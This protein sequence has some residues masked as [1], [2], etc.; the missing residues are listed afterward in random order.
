MIWRLAWM[1]VLFCCTAVAGW[2]ETRHA[3]LIAVSDYHA[4][5][6]ALAPPLEGPPNDIALMW[7]VLSEEG[8][9]PN[10]ITVLA[11]T[12]LPATAE[13]LADARAPTRAAILETLGALAERVSAGDDIL[14]YFSGHGAQ[15]PDL[16]GQTH[17]SEPDGLDEAYLPADFR[18]EQGAAGPRYVNAIRDDEIGA[19]IDRMI[20][21]G[22][23]VWLVADTCHAGTLR[24]GAPTALVPRQVSLGHVPV[25]RA[26]SA[27]V[28]APLRAASGAFVAFYGA[29]AG[30]LAYETRLSAGAFGGGAVHGLLTWSLAQAI[31]SG[32]RSYSE[33]AAF[34]E[35]AMWETSQ[36]RA[37]P[38]FSGSLGAVPMLGAQ[39]RRAERFALAVEDGQVRLS[40]GLLDGLEPGQRVRIGWS[41]GYGPSGVLV[42][43]RLGAVGLSGA[44][45][46]VPPA[47]QSASLGLDRQLEAEGLDPRRH[48]ARWLADRAPV[49]RA[50]WDGRDTTES[51]PVE[52][53]LGL[54]PDLPLR[55]SLSVLLDRFPRPLA[56][57]RSPYMLDLEEGQLRLRVTP[58]GPDLAFEATPAGLRALSDRLERLS[59]AA[60]L[61]SVAA[62]LAPSRL[63]EDLKIALSVRP[64]ATAACAGRASPGDRSAE[65][66]V[67]DCDRVT[68]TLR[69]SGPRP[70]DVSPLYVAPDGEVYYLTGYPGSDRGGLRLRPGDQQTVLYREDLSPQGDAPPV[71]GEMAL[72]LLAVEAEEDGRPPADFRFLES[73]G[74][75]PLRR[76][77]GVIDTASRALAS[78]AV[79]I[80]LR[81]AQVAHADIAHD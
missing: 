71:V 2:A 14:L 19:V 30:A 76:D 6:D 8:V 48:R 64:D 37:E 49:L 67:Y 79:T 44:E 42:E 1:S 65:R 7:D 33:L 40:A 54:P 38:D 27:G 56:A 50:M 5:V 11:D 58:E 22:A 46:I 13:G 55:A 73:A 25:A 10:R 20:A 51:I 17:D 45:V 74:R 26:E 72:V 77:A 57:P 34:A 24:R 16:P 47:G 59:F 60:H 32:A 81:T 9:P 43:A 78:G 18:I 28:R 75:V 36:G 68:L 66:I 52:F 12:G 41:E 29:R 31:R 21:H 69:N 61:M 62:R 63:S 23:K 3:V 70:L 4:S 53:G 15:V 35:A 80:P 39:E